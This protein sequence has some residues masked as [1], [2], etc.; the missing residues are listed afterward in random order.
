MH[1]VTVAGDRR[2]AYRVSWRLEVR[3]AHLES[4]PFA[5]GPDVMS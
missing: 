1:A 5:T 2:A 3:N 4:A